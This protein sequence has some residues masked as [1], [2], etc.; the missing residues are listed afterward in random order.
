MAL[1]LNTNSYTSTDTTL[2]DR[3][4]STVY[5]V[6]QQERAHLL[7][8]LT[9]LVDAWRDGTFDYDLLCEKAF[10]V[11]VALT[12]SD[13][14]KEETMTR[15]L[16]LHDLEHDHDLDALVDYL[17]DQ[18]TSGV[19]EQAQVAG[20]PAVGEAPLPQGAVTLHRSSPVT[21]PRDTPTTRVCSWQWLRG[22]LL[23]RFVEARKG[24]TV[25]P[26]THYPLDWWLRTCSISGIKARCRMG[27][28]PVFQVL[29]RDG[30]TWLE[31]KLP[32]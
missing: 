23:A 8:L 15:T 10:R 12:L 30:V 25:T 28:R 21:P 29:D 24:R 2:I 17:A 20:L 32:A 19:Q 26:G 6:A 14:T 11:H 3:A 7:S 1:N 27:T 18:P 16:A 5:L 9:Q 22:Y 31:A 13:P 4:M